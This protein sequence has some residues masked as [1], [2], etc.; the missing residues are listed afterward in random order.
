MLSACATY[1]PEPLPR[2]AD[3]APAITDLKVAAQSFPLPSL[4][5]HPFD[6][7]DGLDWIEIA[8]LAVANNPLLKAA[9]MQRGE[10]SAQVYA[11]GL[12]PDPQLSASLDHPTNGGSE[13]VAG[14]GIGLGYDFQGLITRSAGVAAGKAAQRQVD[15][16]LLWQEWQVIQQARQLTLQIGNAVARRA[17]LEEA[18][19]RFAR[20]YRRARTLMAQGELT[21]ED[22][23]AQA[24]AW[25]ETSHRLSRLRQELQRGQAELHA[26]LGLAPDVRLPLISLAGAP[27]ARS[28][29][30]VPVLTALPR[31]RPDLRALRAGYQSQEQR[32][33]KAILAQFPLLDMGF[34]RD[35]DT[36]GLYTTGVGI[37][38]NL[39]L[40]SGN[41]GRIA[42]ERAT[43][44]RLR[45]EY[46]ARLD[47]TRSDIARLLDR[48]RLLRERYRR[49]Q[50]HLPELAS[51][52][53]AARQ[54]YRR[55]DLT[56]LGW[57]NLE[58]T[59]LDRRLERLALEQ[60]LWQGRIALDT[61]LAWPETE[62]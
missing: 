30:P 18:E 58:K 41:R 60:A 56:A 10:A 27:P 33:R 47:Q 36:D 39:P 14:G 15:L 19:D 49:L 5:H 21:L 8:M 40:F 7:A 43:R 48:Q 46:Q 38:L 25:F 28:A 3:L 4:R 17:L 2:S 59:W 13:R 26:L 12:L 61:L 31:R 9:R 53:T 55:G 11:A 42:I 32:V 20:Q 52:V 23:G 16:V 51:L 24:A 22:V 34:T 45:A 44:A 57:L 62:E 37:T 1:R 50:R 6:V 54:A 29:P 35:R